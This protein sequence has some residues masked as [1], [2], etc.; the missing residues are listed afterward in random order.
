MWSEL[1]A[2]SLATITRHKWR[3]ISILCF[4]PSSHTSTP[5]PG[6]LCPFKL[7]CSAFT[8]YLFFCFSFLHAQEAA[9]SFWPL[10]SRGI[11]GILALDL[12]HH[13]WINRPI[14]MSFL[15][16]FRTVLARE[17]QPP[18]CPCWPAQAPTDQ[19]VIFAPWSSLSEAAR[20]SLSRG[21]ES[22]F[23]CSCDLKRQALLYHKAPRKT[24]AQNKNRSLSLW[25]LSASFLNFSFFSCTYSQ[26]KLKP[27]VSGYQVTVGKTTGSIMCIYF[28][29]KCH[30]MLSWC[31]Y[32]KLQWVWKVDMKC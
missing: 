25:S 26:Q 10:Y 12:G 2:L 30:Y 13:C 32:Y 18:A 11:S 31:T 21:R 24:I 27:S 19:S 20:S 4:S 17:P 22:H 6:I 5:Y 9:L 14:L 23:S 15:L 1:K 29:S 3:E 7:L 28:Y 16:V 8:I